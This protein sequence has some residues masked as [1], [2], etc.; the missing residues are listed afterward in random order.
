MKTSM[1]GISGMYSSVLSL[2]A[3]SY[4][5]GSCTTAGSDYVSP[6]QSGNTRRRRFLADATMPREG[7]ITITICD[8]SSEEGPESFEVYITDEMLQNAFIYPNR[9]ATVT[10]VDNDQSK[11]VV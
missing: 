4:T 8:D 1:H 2:S 7:D 10:I 6:P 3:F 5:D 11:C 9:V